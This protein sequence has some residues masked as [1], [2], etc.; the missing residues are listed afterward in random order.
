MGKGSFCF[1]LS[2]KIIYLNVYHL[3]QEELVFSKAGNIRW[4]RQSYFIT[5]DEKGECST[6]Q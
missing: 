2:N 1:T 5:I 3:N 4:Y 6:L